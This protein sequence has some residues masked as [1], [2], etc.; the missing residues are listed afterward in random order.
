MYP[1]QVIIST[2]GAQAMAVVDKIRSGDIQ[3][4]YEETILVGDRDRITLIF[5]SP[6]EATDPHWHLDFDEWWIVVTGLLEWTT[7]EAPTKDIFY[8]IE[9][10]KHTLST[11]DLIYVPRHYKHSIK[12]VGDAPSCR[13][14]IATPLAPHIWEKRWV[15]ENLDEFLPR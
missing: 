6:G 7:S 9:D 4:P 14:A 2:A 8:E 12:N 1:T 3:T 11:G 15:G 10:L 5:N 13:M